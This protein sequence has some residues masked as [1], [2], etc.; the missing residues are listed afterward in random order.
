MRK[1]GW[2]I[3]L[4]FVQLLV[5]GQDTIFKRNGEIVS[6]KVLEIN[7]SEISYKRSD[8]PDGPLIIAAKNDIRKI[9][10]ATGMIDSFKVTQPPIQEHGNRTLVKVQ[11]NSEL[12]KLGMR[13]GVYIYQGHN[14]PDR[15]LFNLAN[16]RNHEWNNKEITN[17][18]LAS[19]KNKALQYAIGYGGAA[20]GV[21]CLF[22]S[23]FAVSENTGNDNVILS[24]AAAS[25]GIAS[26]VSS[27]I[28]SFS[29]KLKRVKHADKVMEL[30]N[31]S[32]R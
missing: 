19:K 17:N 31:Q 14:I 12:I 26:I 13:R 3:L 2:I 15:K 11:V 5:N 28:V 10:Y 18:I 4:C 9:K 6:A 22:G 29:F 7:I 27:Q 32:L 24:M 25:I 23:A 21:A 1:S 30:Y 8:L 20:F 16:N